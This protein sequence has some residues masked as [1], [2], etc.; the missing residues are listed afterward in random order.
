M[1]HESPGLIQVLV[2]ESIWQPIQAWS[3]SLVGDRL[4]DL[5][6]GKNGLTE[7]IAMPG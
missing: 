5:V 6:V 3:V 1:S 7:S 2:G 4:V